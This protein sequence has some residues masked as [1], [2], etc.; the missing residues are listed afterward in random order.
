[1]S[2]TWIEKAPALFSDY[3]PMWRAQSAAPET[4]VK[5]AD[6]GGSGLGMGVGGR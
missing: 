2:R 5:M 4:G 1:M 3:P 6:V